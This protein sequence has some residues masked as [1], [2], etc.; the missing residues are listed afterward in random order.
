MYFICQVT[1]HIY[2]NFQILFIF[3]YEP[4]SLVNASTVASRFF[5]EHGGHSVW[6]EKRDFRI[7]NRVCYWCSIYLRN[8][9]ATHEPKGE[10]LGN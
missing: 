10:V 7:D 3:A 9:E 4:I 1:H 2:I 6:S 5:Y 8:H